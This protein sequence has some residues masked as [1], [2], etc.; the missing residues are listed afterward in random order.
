MHFERY[1]GSRDDDVLDAVHVLK[2]PLIACMVR[3]SVSQEHAVQ[4]VHEI[5]TGKTNSELK[6][7]PKIAKIHTHTCIH[8]DVQTYKHT[9]CINQTVVKLYKKLF[10]DKNGTETLHTTSKRILGN[11]DN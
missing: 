3:T 1:P 9:H 6:T 2:D 10:L 4:T 8:T 5:V 7:C 11:H